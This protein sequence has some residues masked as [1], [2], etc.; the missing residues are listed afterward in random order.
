MQSGVS[1]TASRDQIK[2][3]GK[4]F[5]NAK[6]RRSSRKHSQ[7]FS[8]YIIQVLEQDSV[9]PKLL[10]FFSF[11]C[12]SLHTLGNV[13]VIPPSTLLLSSLESDLFVIMTLFSRRLILISWKSILPLSQIVWMWRKE[14]HTHKKNSDLIYKY[15]SCHCRKRHFFTTFSG[16]SALCTR[17]LLFLI[18]LCFCHP[19]KHI[20]TSNSINIVNL[21]KCNLFIF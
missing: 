17:P 15:T 13:Q 12:L 10:F 5:F 21:S 9:L 18:C 8:R 14:E 11:L 19:I 4:V 6:C 2:A 1:V 7:V 3:T 20:K 16:G